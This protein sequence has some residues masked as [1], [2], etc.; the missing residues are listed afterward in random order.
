MTVLADLPA[1]QRA[2]LELV[3][4]RGRN[5]DQIAG[6]LGIDR[7]AV[8][9][10]ALAALDALGPR[11]DLAPM[12]RALITD[13]LL[14]QLPA[15]VGEEVHRRLAHE[16][17]E[18]AWARVVASELAT[19][20]SG[21]LPEIPPAAGSGEPDTVISEAE[22]AEPAGGED[23]RAPAGVAVTG[24]FQG[25]AARRSSRRGGAIVLGL[26]AAIVVAVIVIIIVFVAGG[27]SKHGA[28]TTA[29]ST[30]SVS[31]TG[32]SPCTGGT[33]AAP[34][35]AGATNVCVMRL[36]SPTA[37]SKAA[38]IAATFTES[39]KRWLALVAANL[40]PND[41]RPGHRN[42][43]AVWLTS[44]AGH[45]VFLGFAPTV[46]SN[47]R[48]ETAQPGLPQSDAAYKDILLTLETTLHPKTPG[49]VVIGGLFRLK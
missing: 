26:G 41:V 15:A 31:R 37:G 14:G 19:L 18:R 38:G 4:A 34:L 36:L 24:I 1:D 5:Y 12:R 7:A 40:P 6:L 33:S 10:R 45:S 16:A 25:P 11:T 47:G 3:L 49:Q 20:A 2:V 48:L 42:Y 28:T 32:S 8:R 44:G 9:E 17:A 46:G 21:A 22:G 30:S 23:D 27:S 39:G 13:Y 29:G 35:A 43:Y